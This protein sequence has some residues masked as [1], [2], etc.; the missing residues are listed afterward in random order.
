M[1]HISLSSTAFPYPT[2]T[3]I[4][5]SY[6]FIPALVFEIAARTKKKRKKNHCYNHCMLS[7]NLNQNIM[8]VLLQYT[9]TL[10]LA[11]PYK[12]GQE[13]LHLSSLTVNTVSTE[14]FPHKTYCP[15]L[16]NTF[17]FWLKSNKNN[18]Y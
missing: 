11:T 15:K 4:C 10:H 9:I 12:I 5:L 8:H 13:L 2:H 6:L 17:H 7:N 18:R 14:Y 3:T 16:F 1:L